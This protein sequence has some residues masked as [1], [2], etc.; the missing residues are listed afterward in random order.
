MK[1]GIVIT[2]IFTYEKHL[3]NYILTVPTCAEKII[4]T[5]KSQEE[6]TTFISNLKGLGL[7]RSGEC[8]VFPKLEES[9]Q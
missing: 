4:K 1:F 9:R 7:W 3:A 6:H 5:K 2:V 8:S